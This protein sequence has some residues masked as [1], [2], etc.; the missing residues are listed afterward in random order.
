MLGTE[1]EGV[2]RE[3]SNM[4][5]L[6]RRSNTLRPMSCKPCYWW[7]GCWRS[8][9]EGGF[10]LLWPSSLRFPA[11][12][13]QCQDYNSSAV[14]TVFSILHGPRPSSNPPSNI[15]HPSVGTMYPFDGR[16]RVLGDKSLWDFCDSTS[17]WCGSIS[18]QSRGPHPLG[19]SLN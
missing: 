13:Y 9:A 16:R 7:V 5:V 1:V 12:L 17:L 14:G 4:R 19:R 6:L 11:L 18:K 15:Q 10:L 3:R 2:L 8:I